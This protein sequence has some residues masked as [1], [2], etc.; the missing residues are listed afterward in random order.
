MTILTVVRD[1]CAVVGVVTPTSVFAALAANRTMQE[2]VN[3]AN[4]MAQRIAYDTR[5]WTRLKTAAYFTGDGVTTAWDLPANYKR[6]LPTTNVWSSTSMHTPMMFIPDTDEWMRRRALNE[7]DSRGEWTLLG[8]HMHIWPPLGALPPLTASF[9]YLDRNCV[10]LASG[11]YGDRFQTDDDSFRLD[12]RLLKLGMTWQWKAQK[13]SPY[14]EDMGTYSDAL[15][16]AMRNDGPAPIIIDR[17][18]VSRW[19]RHAIY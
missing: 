19:T 12:E 15:Q 13:G 1:V 8:D 3:L 17:L 18:P 14:S 7:T 6:M 16:V 11:G 10:S 5:D 4:E 2:M 9:T